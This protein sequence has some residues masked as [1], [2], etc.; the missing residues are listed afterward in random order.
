MAGEGAPNCAQIQKNFLQS[1][2]RGGECG[3]QGYT[4][5]PPLPLKPAGSRLW[6]LSPSRAHVLCARAADP[7]VQDGVK[8]AQD[9][10]NLR[11]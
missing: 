2:M 11:E 10:Q 4:T 3:S 6:R 1:G 5:L 8:A 9:R 7:R